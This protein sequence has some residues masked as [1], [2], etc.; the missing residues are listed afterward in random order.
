MNNYLQTRELF[1]DQNDVSSAYQIICGS[2]LYL[3][4]EELTARIIC[5]SRK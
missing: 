4:I 2:K 1:A 3:Q 5:R